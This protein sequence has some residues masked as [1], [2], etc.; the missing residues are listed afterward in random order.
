MA[1][2]SISKV[3]IANMGL[4][5]LGERSTIESF[6]ERTS[7]AEA[8]RLWY[9]FAR[10]ACLEAFNWNFARRRRALTSHS[11]D[12]P[13]QWAFRYQYPTDCVAAR[14]I[15]GTIRR[16]FNPANN[17]PAY[18]D[19]EDAVAFDVEEGED[20]TT[21]SV[22]TDQDEAVLIY[23]RDVQ[24]TSLFSVHF[25]LTLSHLLAYLMGNTL[26]G[27]QALREKQLFAYDRLIRSAASVDA[28]ERVPRPPR[29]AK[30]IRAR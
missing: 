16:P 21:K 28:N 20:G 24:Q 18:Y 14:E 29:N 5:H 4:S 15:E 12:P 19:D 10:L 7:E 9:E 23:T 27:K 11:D 13:D 8:V 17:L 3:Q 25:V 1:N 26:T 22:L 6:D 30:H 2:I